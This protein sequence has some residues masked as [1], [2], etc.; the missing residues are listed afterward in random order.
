M[1]GV[2]LRLRVSR[3]GFDQAHLRHDVPIARPDVRLPR[4]HPD[5]RR[6][7]AEL[8]VPDEEVPELESRSVD[9]IRRVVAPAGDPADTATTPA[10]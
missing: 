5:T 2:P 6:G 10:S 7:I 1:Y 8:L 3:T 9:V 4:L